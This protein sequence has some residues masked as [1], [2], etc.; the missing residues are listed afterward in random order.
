[1]LSLNKT[2][3]HQ[4]AAG[5]YCRRV[6][7]TS[8]NRLGSQTQSFGDGGSMSGFWKADLHWAIYE[9]RARTKTNLLNEQR[10]VRTN[11]SHA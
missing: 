11:R 5:D 2:V 9:V 6:V 7:C 8:Y 1:V 4:E 10:L 3:A